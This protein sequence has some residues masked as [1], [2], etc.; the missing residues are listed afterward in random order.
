MSRKLRSMKPRKVNRG[1]FEEQKQREENKTQNQRALLFILPLVMIAILA[2]GIFFGYK[3]YV[4]SVSELNPV[5]PSEFA[6]DDTV[7]DNPMFLRAVNSGSK[8]DADFVPETVECCGI[9]IDKCAADSL[10]KMVDDAAQ[11]GFDL[12]VRGGYTSYE[13]L[14]TQYREAVD[15]Y[16]DSSKSSL[17]MAE[18]HVKKET[19]P[20]GENELQTGL[21]VYLTVKTDGKFADTAAYSW[22]MR[23]SVDYGFVLRYPDQ[24]NAGGM[25]YS[26]HLFRYIGRTH[27][28]KMRALNMDFDEY[29]AYL[30]AQ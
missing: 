14:D 5:A 24:E 9:Q 13:D 20:A 11:N 29:L 4:N 25:S 15:D 27:A 30:A 16:R 23:H 28:Y 8:I 2:V 3:F 26:S 18:A 7:S 1:A 10:Q 6:Q 12:I 17:I 21:V 19:P 22:L